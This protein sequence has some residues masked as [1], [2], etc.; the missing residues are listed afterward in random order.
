MIFDLQ[1]TDRALLEEA[2]TTAYR[3]RDYAGCLQR[4]E[5]LIPQYPLQA[6]YFKLLSEVQ[7][8][9]G[10][11]AEGQL[12]H[13]R[14]LQLVQIEDNTKPAAGVD[15]MHSLWARKTQPN[16]CLE[17]EGFVFAGFRMAAFGSGSLAVA[18]SICGN[19]FIKIC[20]E[21]ELWPAFERESAF[22]KTLTTAGCV[23]AAQLIGCGSFAEGN[24]LKQPPGRYQILSYQRADRG[25]FGF[26][27]LVLALLEQQAAGVYNGALTIRNLRYDCMDKICRFANYES[28]V[29]LTKAEQSLSPQAF[30]DWC[31]EKEQ[32][33]VAA[34]GAV[35]FFLGS[36]AGNDWIWKSGRLHLFA[37]QLF[38]DIRL[39]R[40]SEPSLQ[41]VDTSKLVITQGEDWHSKLAALQ[42]LGFAP[43]STVLDVGCGLGAASMALGK[44][45]CRVTGLEIEPQQVLSAKIIATSEGSQNDFRLHDLD[46]Q[47]LQGQ[48]DVVLL[49]NSFQHFSE[50]KAAAKRIS[51]AC[52][53]RIYIECGLNE[54]G[55]K[56]VGR[57]YRHFGAWEFSCE[58]QLQNALQEW[59]PGFAQAGDPVSTKNARKL[60]CLERKVQQ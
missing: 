44:L 17:L 15:R 16:E 12:A 4:L 1:P 42:A 13:K 5:V 9:I 20:R 31:A 18:C 28:A 35:S 2:L 45:Q 26:P 14:Y 38:Q 30:M 25:G 50:P 3:A 49:L 34:G 11:V 21:P 23:S 36:R 39:L 22:Y 32:Q 52:R 33:R 48:W 24:S 54:R 56:W 29:Y 59:F 47:D 8:A 43:D 60:Y 40:I 7:F 58:Q 19:A 41:A 51:E 57:W 6:S 53:Q 27:D 37:T 10:R 55:Y 46:Y